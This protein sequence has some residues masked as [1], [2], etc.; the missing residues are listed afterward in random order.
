M[1]PLLVFFICLLRILIISWNFRMQGWKDFG[2]SPAIG[3]MWCLIFVHQYGDFWSVL[4]KKS[5]CPESKS[6]P[7]HMIINVHFSTQIKSLFRTSKTRLKKGRLSI[8]NRYEYWKEVTVML[9]WEKNHKITQIFSNCILFKDL[10]IL[11]YVLSILIT[12]C[13]YLV[14]LTD[15]HF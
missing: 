2:V 12:D 4:P 6:D 3:S 11:R 5:L 1:F 13:S 8:C 10:I 15:Q 7:S 14:S 9:N